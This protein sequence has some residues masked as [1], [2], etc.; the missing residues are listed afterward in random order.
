MTSMMITHAASFK[1]VSHRNLPREGTK[2][3]SPVRKGGVFFTSHGEFA[4]RA[5]H[6]VKR[7]NRTLSIVDTCL[8][9]ASILRLRCPPSAE[10]G[11]SAS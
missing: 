1:A 2:V 10:V 9:D 5:A 6:V 3:G 4:R 8:P 7:P 11:P